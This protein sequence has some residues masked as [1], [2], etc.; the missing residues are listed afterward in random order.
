MKLDRLLSDLFRVLVLLVLV[1][2]TLYW[3]DP[4]NTV[5]FQASLIGIFLVG[6]THLTRRVLFPLLDLQ[7]IAKDAIKE[8]NMAGTIIF[9]AIIYFLVSVMNLSMMIL[10]Q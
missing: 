2:F 4:S 10:K 8:N 3:I 9:C 1:G 6:G 5:V 7:A